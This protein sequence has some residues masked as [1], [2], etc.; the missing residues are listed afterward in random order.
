MMRWPTV[1]LGRKCR[2][3]SGRPDAL[4]NK[5]HKRV[6]MNGIVCGVPSA[7]QHAD[8]DM[9]LGATGVLM[10]DGP[11]QEVAFQDAEGP[12]DHR[13]LHV[14]FPK[15]LRRLAALIAA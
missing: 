11:Q 12:F 7:S 2:P 1:S 14:R 15:L 10:P 13:Q 3:I 6:T 4:L 5:C 8:E 9:G